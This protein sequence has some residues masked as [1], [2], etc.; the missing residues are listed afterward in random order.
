[1]I[2]S[3]LPGPRLLGPL[4]A[5]LRAARGWSQQ[6]LADELCAAS[7]VPTLTRNEVS[8]WERQ[9]RL[10]GDFWSAW[11][12]T[13]LRLPGEVL[14]EAAARSRRLGVAPAM[15][16]PAG[17][18]ARLALLTL[19]Y[20]WAAEPGGR[21][22]TGPFAAAPPRHGRPGR[23]DGGTPADEALSLGVPGGPDEPA[24]RGHPADRVTLATL[25]RWDDLLGGGDLAGHGAR[26]LRHAVRGY[27]RAGPAGRRGLLPALAESAQLAGWLAA[28]AGDPGGGLVAYRLALR[29]AVAAGQP[30]LA[31]HVLASASHLLADAGDP[32]GALV[33]ARIGYAAARADATPGLRALLLHRMALAAALAGRARAAGQALAGADRAGTPEPGREPPWLYWLD[34]AE[35]AAMTGRTLVALGRPAAAVPLLTPVVGAPGRPRRSAVYGGWLARGHL[36]LGAVPEACAVAGEALLDAVR[37]GSARATGQLTAFRRGLAQAPPA[38]ATRGY[39]RLVTAARPYLPSG[40]PRHL[41]DRPGR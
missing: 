41:R 6:R 7:G 1:M 23:D 28:D 32:A 20:R 3:P 15:V 26:R 36:G 34:A 2:P 11:L 12:A 4:L 40:V 8:R 19:A 9:L 22:L 16:D 31:G 21:T 39:A 10:P 5:E 37:S 18:R 27:R 14:A 24:G 25:R 33:L 38:P 30:P 13:V 29:A 35:L 17:S